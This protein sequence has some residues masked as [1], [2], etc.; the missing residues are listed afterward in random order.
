[1][2]PLPL[3]DNLLR[4]ALLYVFLLAVLRLLGRREI[5]A[6]SP[7]DFL[8]A[9]MIGDVLGMTIFGDAEL[10]D[11]LAVIA[12]I[13]LMHFANSW[14]ACRSSVFARLVEGGPVL[15]VENGQ[16]RSQELLRER[17]SRDELLALL[18]LQ[19]IGPDDLAEID[20]AHLEV[21]GELSVLKQKPAQTAQKQ[22]LRGAEK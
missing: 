6:F 3:H 17:L 5:G 13:G 2:V 14:L 21:D 15:V 12:L 20:K 11:G 16:I 19:G 8:I 9:L 18:R 7:F 1:M 4:T 10:V 22:D